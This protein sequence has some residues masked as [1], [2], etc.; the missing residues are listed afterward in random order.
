MLPEVLGRLLPFLTIMVLHLSEDNII[1]PGP[2]IFRSPTSEMRADTGKLE[3]QI[4]ALRF[5][6]CLQEQLRECH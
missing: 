2:T 4:A 3:D 6:G 5:P 1:T